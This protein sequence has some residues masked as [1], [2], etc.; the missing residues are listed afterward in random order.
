MLE[1]LSDHTT[2]QLTRLQIVFSAEDP[3][4]FAK[5]VAS[6]YRLRNEA[7][8][9]MRYN[10][11]IDCMPLDDAPR[12]TE[13]QLERVM[14]LAINTRQLRYFAANR[15]E[16]ADEMT[17]DYARTMNKIV[18]QA[19]HKES[20]GLSPTDQA[21]NHA[22]LSHVPIP[23]RSKA[24]LST[25]PVMAVVDVP[26]YDFPLQFNH[27]SFHSFSTQP[28]VIRAAVRCASEV[29]SIDDVSCAC[30]VALHF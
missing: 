17:R 8:A 19:N 30:A 11:F 9:W 22:L 24:Q 27:F 7:A 21:R 6:A 26:P 1:S 14:R 20:L 25:P 16:L 13:E 3:H 4:Q 10:L 28:Q 18:F 23:A 5:R 2:S 12:P 15:D 29:L